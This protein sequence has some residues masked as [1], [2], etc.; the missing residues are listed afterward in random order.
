[1]QVSGDEVERLVRKM[2]YCGIRSK[3]LEIVR[4]KNT[5]GSR[6]DVQK[7]DFGATDFITLNT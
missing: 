4:A 3:A 6:T 5:S 2:V 1:M 7:R